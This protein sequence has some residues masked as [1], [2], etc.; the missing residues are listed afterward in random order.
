[1]RIGLALVLALGACGG[2]SNEAEAE[3]AYL[4]L[5]AMVEKAL[6]L[7]M[8]G[9]NA[10]DSANIP[11]QSGDGEVSG[12]IVVGGQVDQGASDNKELRLTVDLV[13]YAD[14]VDLDGDD[15]D[16]LFEVT[17]ETPEGSPLD[18]DVSL[19]DIPDGTLAGTLAGAVRMAGDLEGDVVLDLDMTGDIEA[20][21]G[22]TD[23]LR[24]VD[25]TTHV[26]GTATSDYG[27]FDVDVTR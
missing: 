23:G 26:T 5:D 8:A 15:D 4:G 6:N 18:L 2:V 27:V 12:T 19:R 22:V 13:D 11:D 14:E 20:D 25:G 10:A 16:D 17:Y 7:G 1:M 9:Y 3:R 24:R 21:P